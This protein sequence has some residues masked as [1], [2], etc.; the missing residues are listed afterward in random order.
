MIIDDLV[1]LA[2]FTPRSKA[3]AQAMDQAGIYPQKVITFGDQ[4]ND[5]PASHVNNAHGNVDCDGEP[6]FLPD[7]SMTLNQTLTRFPSNILHIDAAYVDDPKLRPHIL[8]DSNLAIIYS[9]YGGQ[10]VGADTLGVAAPF[11]HMHCGWL[12]DFRG[13]TTIYYSWLAGEKTGVTSIQL[14]PQIDTG[15]ILAKRQYPN[16]PVGIDIDHVYDGALRA[17]MLIRVLREIAEK[18]AL[19]VGDSQNTDGTTYYV[20]HP[21]LRHIA[22]L[23]AQRSNIKPKI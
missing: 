7:M 23:H 2:A 20:M 3:Y 9:G 19:P 4:S 21:V 1:F 17:D 18:G 16:P 13:S 22:S 10:I 14:D 6:L 12:P 15:S 8:A 11:I 5:K